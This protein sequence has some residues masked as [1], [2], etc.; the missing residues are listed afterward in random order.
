MA[1]VTPP[2]PEFDNPTLEALA[3]W[4]YKPA[5]CNGTP[6]RINTIITTA[7]GL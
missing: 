2:R 3:K 7:Y 5:M 6:Q 1:I 4:R